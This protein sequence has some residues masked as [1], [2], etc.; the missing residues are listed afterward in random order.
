ME[1]G[2]D[3]SLSTEVSSMM[4]PA[5]R[6]T[7][8]PVV[9]DEFFGLTCQFLHGRMAGGARLH[10][11]NTRHGGRVAKLSQAVAGAGIDHVWERASISSGC[12]ERNRAQQAVRRTG[13]GATARAQR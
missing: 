6:R 13:V 12:R 7:S 5:R 11:L 8:G 1:V 3:V 4:L 2:S 10:V 9:P